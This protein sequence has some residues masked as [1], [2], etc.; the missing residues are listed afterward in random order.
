[1]YVCW[2]VYLSLSL[3]VQAYSGT[4]GHGTYVTARHRNGQEEVL[5]KHPLRTDPEGKHFKSKSDVAATHQIGSKWHHR[6]RPKPAP[7]LALS[8]N[9]FEGSRNSKGLY[10]RLRDITAEIQPNFP[11]QNPL[12]LLSRKLRGLHYPRKSQV[13]I[14]NSGPRLKT[15]VTYVSPAR[16]GTHTLR[17]LTQKRKHG[18]TP[19]RKRILQP[20]K[21]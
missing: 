11:S 5:K 20:Q 2:L 14:L 9:P 18:P 21:R 7:A 6:R 16:P 10:C 15:A 12:H 17:E 3:I 19:R 4:C 1:M 8:T 13:K